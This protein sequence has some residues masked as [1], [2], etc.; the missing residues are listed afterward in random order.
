[1]SIS[2]MRISLKPG[3]VREKKNKK[4]QVIKEIITE[5]TESKPTDS[6]Q[7][8]SRET[9]HPLHNVG[10]FGYGKTLTTWSNN[11]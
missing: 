5:I 2:N 4:Y 9:L 10:L 6:K 1:M 7:G 11:M 8:Y 3:K